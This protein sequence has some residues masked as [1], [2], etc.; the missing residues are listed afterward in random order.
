MAGPVERLL[1]SQVCQNDIKQQL[2]LSNHY[3]SPM[4]T[5]RTWQE[6]T[7]RSVHHRTCGQADLGFCDFIQFI[8][9]D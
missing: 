7:G 8:E 1:M 9:G 5:K 2:R 4:R 3:S 6:S